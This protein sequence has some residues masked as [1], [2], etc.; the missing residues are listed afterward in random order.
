VAGRV[1]A[2]W[3]GAYAKSTK[4]QYVFAPSCLEPLTVMMGGREAQLELCGNLRVY[5][6][7]GAEN[8]TRRVSLNNDLVDY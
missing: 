7:K 6:V 2:G 5:Q 1:L 4:F 8:A 3:G